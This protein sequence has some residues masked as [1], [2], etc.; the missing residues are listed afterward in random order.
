LQTVIAADSPLRRDFERVILLANDSNSR[1]YVI[2]A[3]QA[4]GTNLGIWYAD[5]SNPVLF[6]ALRTFGAVGTDAGLM[7]LRKV[8]SAQGDAQKTLLAKLG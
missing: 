1:Y 5:L 2:Y 8:V 6:T 3:D 7:A 4:E